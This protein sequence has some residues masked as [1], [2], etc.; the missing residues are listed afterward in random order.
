MS[1]LETSRRFSEGMSVPGTFETWLGLLK[2][3]QAAAQ[4]RQFGMGSLFVIVHKPRVTSHV[5]GQYCR[6][7]ALNPDWPLLHHDRYP[8]SMLLYDGSGEM[9]IQAICRLLARLRHAD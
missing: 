6:Q 2:E 3:A 8:T 1:P 4:R 5:G 9:P 7:L